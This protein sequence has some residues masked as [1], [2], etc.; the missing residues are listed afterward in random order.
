VDVS[1]PPKDN[2][3]ARVTA[4]VMT[5]GDEWSVAFQFDQKARRPYPTLRPRT[6]AAPAQI[7]NAELLEI[8]RGTPRDLLKLTRRDR[9]S[10]L[11]ESLERLGDRESLNRGALMLAIAGS[12]KRHIVERAETGERVPQASAA[13][14]ARKRRLGL[15]LTPMRA[16]GQLLGAL[17]RAQIVLQRP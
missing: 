7:A 4:L 14:L 12:Y 6:K 10:V 15:A 8:Y 5:L 13:W 1:A 3:R 17:R 16:S 9:A 2:A 11:R